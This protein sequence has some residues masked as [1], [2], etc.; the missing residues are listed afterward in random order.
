MSAARLERILVGVKTRMEGKLTGSRV[1]N[2]SHNDWPGGKKL[3]ME[4]KNDSVGTNSISFEIFEA[5][6][7]CAIII[8]ALLSTNL[9]EKLS[10]KV[11]DALAKEAREQGYSQIVYNEA[12]GRQD[13]ILNA[14]GYKCRKPFKSARTGSIIRTWLQMLT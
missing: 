13:T 8:V 9:D 6:T 10:I 5:P 12:N 11:L 3:T 14:A 1:T 7:C 2:T 4:K